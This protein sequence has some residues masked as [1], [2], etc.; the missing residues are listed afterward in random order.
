MFDVALTRDR[1]SRLEELLAAS[2]GGTEAGGL[3]SEMASS[4]GAERVGVFLLTGK[5]A[6]A[7]VLVLSLKKGDDEP[8]VAGEFSW[9]ERADETGAAAANAA[10]LLESAGWPAISGDTRRAAPWYHKWWF[11]ALVGAAIAGAAAGAGGGGGSS[12]GSTGAIGVNF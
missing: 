6:M 2:S 1:L 12:G 4:A 9:P 5:G 11:W 7:R 3:L 8:T 10:S